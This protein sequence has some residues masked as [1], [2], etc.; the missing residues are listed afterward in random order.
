[1]YFSI[2]SFDFVPYSISTINLQAVGWGGEGEGGNVREA[3]LYRKGKQRALQL[4]GKDEIRSGCCCGLSSG[5]GKTIGTREERSPST[6][7]G[8][9]CKH[10]CHVAFSPNP[11][12]KLRDV[13][14][15]VA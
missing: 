9:C 7:S 14:R 12:L 4:L 10:S 13:S 8:K 15:L 1:M 3:S 5:R 2:L 11:T 6:G